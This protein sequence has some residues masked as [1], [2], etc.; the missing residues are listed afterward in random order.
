MLFR[1]QGARV[2]E[3]VIGRDA[4]HKLLVWCDSFD[5]GMAGNVRGFL[6]MQKS[7]NRISSAA[8]ITLLPGRVGTWMK[9]STALINAA[10]SSDEIDPHEWAASMARMAAGRLVLSPRALME[11][12]A[13]DARDAT[14]TAVIREAMSADEAGRSASGAWKK[15][16][17]GRGGRPESCGRQNS[18]LPE[19]G[20][21]AGALAAA[22]KPLSPTPRA[23]RT[24]C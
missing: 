15:A 8:A 2:L 7:L 13:L 4:L 20:R 10:F 3:K 23:R 11:R 14:G 18:P 5:K 9:Q 24:R 16:R 6:E 19:P 21:A 22:A 1:S 12:A 17:G